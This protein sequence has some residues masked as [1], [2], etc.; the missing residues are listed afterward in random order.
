[1]LDLA[2]PI[3]SPRL[4]TVAGM[5]EP[6]IFKGCRGID[7]PLPG[8]TKNAILAYLGKPNAA[9]WDKLRKHAI[10]GRISLGEA[11][12]LSNPGAARRFPTSV[13]LIRAMRVA[14]ISQWAGSVVG[15]ARD[16]NVEPR[17]KASIGH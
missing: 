8:A 6:G 4:D 5:N 13:E 12:T 9:S 2:E 14:V 15:P 3:P 11:W 16:I 7:G 1:M 10:V 17:P